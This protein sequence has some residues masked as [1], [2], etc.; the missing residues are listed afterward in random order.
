MYTDTAKEEQAGR[1][2]TTMKLYFSD[3]HCRSAL[4][5]GRHQWHP[6]NWA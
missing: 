6:L 1:R 4:V 5:A 2:A 3:T